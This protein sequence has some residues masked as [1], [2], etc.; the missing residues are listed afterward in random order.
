MKFRIVK[1]ILLILVFTTFLSAQTGVFKSYH[2][3]C[4]KSAEISYSNGIYDGI[5]N[6]Y[7]DNGN[8]QETKTF[9]NGKLNGWCRSY[10]ESGLL[11]EEK[12]VKEGYIDGIVKRYF[13]NGAL[14]EIINYEKGKLVKITTFEY[15][16]YYQAPIEAYRAGNQ[17]KI[18][19]KKSDEFLCDAK[20]C[21]QPLGGMSSIYEKLIYPPDAKAYG[22]EG[23]VRLIVTV[24][25][26]GVVT[27]TKVMK[28]IGLGCDEAAI[29]A[30]R[31][32]RFLP[33]QNDSGPT[34][35]NLT[36]NVEFKLEKSEEVAA[37]REVPKYVQESEQNYSSPTIG[38][39]TTRITPE[40]PPDQSSQLKEET[41]IESVISEETRVAISPIDNF[42]CSGV[43]VCAKPKDGIRAVIN[44]FKIPQ[45]VRD[46]N[47]KGNVIIL[48]DVDETGR[49]TNTTVIKD[50]SHGA[51]IAAEVA[52]IRT[53]FEPAQLNGKPVRSKVTVTVPVN[54]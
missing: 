9:A 5:S 14:K 46:N 20:I 15:D 42:N 24:D 30:V 2:M 10:Y 33:G 27:D 26:N 25:R 12:F 18:A 50:L 35:S 17:Q 13:A 39:S 3:N 43:D 29:E 11:K 47:V 38:H 37:A 52:L 1:I 49:V 36:L 48:C 32:T 51:G 6:W 22:L 21:P 41:K 31:K 8:L 23:I 4:K 7:Y 54:Y 53:K 28:G 40:N 16:P 44:N 34:T 45:R 19:Q